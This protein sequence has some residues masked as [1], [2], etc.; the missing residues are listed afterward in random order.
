MG[1]GPG[2]WILAI[3]ALFVPPLSVFIKVGCGAHFWINIILWFLF[4]LPGLL[5]AWYII[6][7]YEDGNSFVI[8][9]DQDH[10]HHHHHHN[11][12]YHRV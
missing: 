12:G 6:F 2:D 10:H 8:R 3:I 7:F 11:D 5:H 4:V 9:V 1:C